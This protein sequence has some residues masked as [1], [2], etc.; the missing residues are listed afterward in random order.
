MSHH[1]DMFD[2]RPQPQYWYRAKIKQAQMNTI[3]LTLYANT[4]TLVAAIKLGATQHRYKPA[5]ADVILQVF[6]KTKGDTSVGTHKSSLSI[7]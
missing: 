2:D 1:L 5:Y 7:D 4:H 3:M 6:G